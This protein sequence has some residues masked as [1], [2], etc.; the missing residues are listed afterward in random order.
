MRDMAEERTITTASAEETEAF[1][2]R[3]ATLL[4]P[5]DV[6]CLTGDLGAGKTTLTRG[7]V[8]GLESPAPVSSPTFTLIH[9]YEGGN[10][11]VYHVDAYRLGGTAE[12]LSVGLEEYLQ[13]EDGVT[14]VEWWQNI[15]SVLPPD[16][17]EIELAE[18]D[19]DGREITLRPLGS[20]WS[21][22][23]TEAL[24]C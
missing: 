8:R 18:A 9:E 6:L 11:P 22:V 13:R 1:G 12:A 16:R 19:G 15:E 20:R 3:L 4:L 23:L 14:V 17:L 5:G 10:L 21:V 24:P 2:E 7:I